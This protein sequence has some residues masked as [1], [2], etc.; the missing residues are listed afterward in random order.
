M[1][2]DIFQSSLKSLHAAMSDY[3][4]LVGEPCPLLGQMNMRLIEFIGCLPPGDTD[5]AK[6]LYTL[7]AIS[8]EAAILGILDRLKE[9]TNTYNAIE[10]RIKAN[11]SMKSIIDCMKVTESINTSERCTVFFNVLGM[12]IAQ[13]KE[14]T[15]AEYPQLTDADGKKLRGEQ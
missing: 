3:L 15:G 5:Q 9:L 7:A 1:A 4:L 8:L 2:K 12:A 10:L 6:T 14:I 11:A 13:L